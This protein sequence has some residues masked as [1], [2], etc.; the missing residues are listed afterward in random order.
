MD[1]GWD[2][3]KSG[4]MTHSTALG[5]LPLEDFLEGGSALPSPW[6]PFYFQTFPGDLSSGEPQRCCLFRIPRMLITR[7]LHLLVRDGGAKG[8]PCATSSWK[9]FLF[10]T[11]FTGRYLGGALARTLLS[12][13]VLLSAFQF[14]CLPS[15]HGSRWHFYF[16]PHWW[17]YLWTTMINTRLKLEVK[18]SR[19]YYLLSIMEHEWGWKSSLQSSEASKDVLGTYAASNAPQRLEPSIMRE[20]QFEEFGIKNYSE[21]ETVLAESK[22]YISTEWLQINGQNSILFICMLRFGKRVKW[23]GYTRLWKTLGFLT[24]LPPTN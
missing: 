13:W 21:I 15:L 17:D 2:E 18:G 9:H 24:N 6:C 14:S 5:S 19:R 10:I 16:S 7:S 4:G 12:L 23:K 22:C 8:H 3:G 20:C 1:G 11:Y